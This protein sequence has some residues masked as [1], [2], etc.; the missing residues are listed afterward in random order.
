MNWIFMGTLSGFTIAL[1]NHSL[2]PTLQMY[3]VELNMF[4]CVDVCLRL[5]RGYHFCLHGI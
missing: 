3:Q 2:D 4:C 5:C 1:A